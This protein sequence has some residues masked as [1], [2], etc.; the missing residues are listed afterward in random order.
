MPGIHQLQECLPGTA[1]IATG[2]LHGGR[3]VSRIVLVS[4]EQW[5]FDR[6]CEGGGGG[7]AVIIVRVWGESVDHDFSDATGITI[8]QGEGWR[9][10]ALSECHP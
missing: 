2:E 4:S 9:G 7:G 10:R 8:N 1:G 6:D 3:R 5:E